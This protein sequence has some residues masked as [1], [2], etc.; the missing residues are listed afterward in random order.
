MVVGAGL[1]LPLLR[2]LNKIIIV[3]INTLNTKS[4]ITVESF[5]AHYSVE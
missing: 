2:S 4:V 3:G 5:C 1:S